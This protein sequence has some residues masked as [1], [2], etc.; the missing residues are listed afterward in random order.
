LRLAKRPTAIFCTNNKTLL[1][2]VRALGESDVSCP[3]EIS[4]IG[5]DDFTWTEN[6][7]PQITTI[8]QPA[9][10]MGIRATAMLIAQ[11]EAADNPELQQTVL[12]P[13]EMRVRQS[14]APPPS[15]SV[16]HKRRNP[17]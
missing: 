9:R 16:N 13:A 10:Q 12:L 5:F 2:L 6:F 8:V 7:R 14:T 15:T 3:D 17:A 11:I 1:G 4:V